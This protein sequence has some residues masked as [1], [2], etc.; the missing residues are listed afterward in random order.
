MKGKSLVLIVFVV[1]CS[2]APSQIQT[3][4][5]SCQSVLSDVDGNANA[6][7]APSAESLYVVGGRAGRGMILRYDGTEWVRMDGAGDNPLFGVWGISNDD[8]YAVGEAGTI[9]HFDGAIWTAEFSGTEAPLRSIWGPY[10]SP[11]IWA[12]GGSSDTSQGVILRYSPSE[13]GGAWVPDPA[14]GIYDS[15]LYQ[16]AGTTLAAWIVGRS[17]DEEALILERQP[18][19]ADGQWE[20]VNVD[21]NI[22]LVALDSR[23]GETLAAGPDPQGLGVVVGYRSSIWQVVQTLPE[24]L[25]GIALGSEDAY[26]VGAFGY[27][28]HSALPVEDD[29]FSSM[30]ACTDRCL[31]SAMS[32]EGWEGVW[33]VG[34]ACPGDS[35]DL[36]VVILLGGGA[37]IGGPVRNLETDAGSPI[38]AGPDGDDGGDAESDATLW[39]G[40]GEE[41]PTGVGCK[42]GL[43]CWFVAQAS[44]FICTHPCSGEAACEDEFGASCCTEP[45]AQTATTVCIP[46]SVGT[47]D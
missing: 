20:R 7:F 16:V 42:P 18:E 40:P 12:V 4:S 32:S 22:N 44:R 11:D 10:G 41:C 23:G 31:R 21:A 25:A 30:E 29:S 43:D 24:P 28:A 5:E 37:V 15:S 39:I 1:A 3:E 19:S 27:V 46:E 9:L 13:G 36:G 2:S 35:V 14:S 26:V 34:G 8:L 45:G 6:V 33:L 47:C 38:D 17:V